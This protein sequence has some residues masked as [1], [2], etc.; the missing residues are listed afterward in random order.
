MK[1]N[2]R[3]IG[4]IVL[5]GIIA[6]TAYVMR[7][8]AEATAPIEAIPLA[9]ATTEVALDPTAVEG[10]VAAVELTATASAT[11]ACEPAPC[12]TT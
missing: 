3:I 9:T 1:K 4:S 2:L 8:S 12:Q 7:P 5:V 11:G 6:V 10:P